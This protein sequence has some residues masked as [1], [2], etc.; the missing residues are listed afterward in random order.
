MKSVIS[1]DDK[2]LKQNKKNEIIKNFW[3]YIEKKYKR[4]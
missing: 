3:K 2:P 4:Q 1:H